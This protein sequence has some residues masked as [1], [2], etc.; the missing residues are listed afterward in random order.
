METTTTTTTAQ[1]QAQQFSDITL[2]QGFWHEVLERFMGFEGLT[3]LDNKWQIHI[4]QLDPENGITDLSSITTWNIRVYNG[5][6]ITEIVEGQSEAQ[7]TAKI[8]EV[9]AF[10]RVV[11]Y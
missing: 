2:A 4:G 11:G 7:V 1:P 3:E 5:M 8:L 9:A 6:A 10:E